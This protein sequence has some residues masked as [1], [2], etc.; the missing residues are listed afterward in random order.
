MSPRKSNTDMIAALEQKLAE[1]RAKEQE[2]FVTRANYLVEAIKSVDE[3][4]AKAE[5]NYSKT[6]AAAAEQR[7]ER[8]DK[9][10]AKRAEL[11]A[12]LNELATTSANKATFSSIK[13]TPEPEVSDDDTADS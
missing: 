4:I 3:R 5:D 11:D 7:D 6:V 9:L 2:K 13:V 12:E 1:A 8:I 10:E